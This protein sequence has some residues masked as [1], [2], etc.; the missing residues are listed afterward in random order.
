M[1]KHNGM[2]SQDIAILLYI[3]QYCESKYRVLDLANALKIS[4]SEISEVLNRNRIAGLLDPVEKIV[5]RNNLYE[6]IIY[7]LK[8]VFPVEPGTI[9]RGIATAHSGPPLN[10]YII[11]NAESYVW[12]LSNGDSQGISVSP[13]Y[14]TL[15]GIAKKVPEFYELLCLVDA[16][17][18]GKAREV[19]LAREILE[20]RLLKK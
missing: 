14:K 5:Y 4:Q 19:K 16:C 15:P 12:S 1:K 7:G 2:K 17:R 10:R 18:I 9:V 8:Y 3:A 20:E 13:L 11:S 6:F